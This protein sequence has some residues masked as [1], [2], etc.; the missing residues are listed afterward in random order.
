MQISDHFSLEEMTR[1]DTAQKM[2]ID[3]TPSYDIERNLHVL[4]WQVLEPARKLCG[5]PFVITSGYRCKRL[6][7]LVGGAPNSYHTMGMAA[8]ILV[9]AH[10]DGEKLT[11]SRQIA[12]ALLKQPLTDLVLIEHDN[13]STWVHVQYSYK[14]RHHY[15]FNYTK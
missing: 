6:N 4:V 12:N 8:D 2:H 5:F 9:N 3:N 15:N 11:I 13:L 7:K 14:P 1:S 10:N